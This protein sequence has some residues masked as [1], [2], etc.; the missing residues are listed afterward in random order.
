MKYAV[1]ALAMTITREQRTHRPAIR[2]RR[3]QHEVQRDQRHENRADEQPVRG[4]GPHAPRAGRAPPRAIERG[5]EPGDDHE[6]HGFHAN[7]RPQACSHESHQKLFLVSMRNWTLPRRGIAVEWIGD[8]DVQH[9]AERRTAVAEAQ[10]EAHVAEQSLRRRAER[11]AAPGGAH[12]VEHGAADVEHLERIPV[13]EQA[14]LGREQP[15]A[16]A[17]LVAQWIAAQAVV[18]A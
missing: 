13:A 5:D 10:T 17:R 3:Q 12:V 11:I 2:H 7:H 18:A 8:I 14:L 4:I 1:A 9:V 6:H 15:A 16:L